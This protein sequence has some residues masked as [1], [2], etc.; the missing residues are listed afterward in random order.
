MDDLF[1]VLEARHQKRVG[2]AAAA[3]AKPDLLQVARQAAEWCAE[4]QHWNTCTSD[5]VAERMTELGHSYDDL[6]NAR[7]SIFRSKKWIFTGDY[8]QSKRPASHAREIKVWRLNH[9]TH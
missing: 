5:D 2:M 8:V 3:D 4:F 7:G 6:G 1:D 9:G